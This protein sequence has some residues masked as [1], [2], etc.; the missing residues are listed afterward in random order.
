LEL[1]GKG[2]RKRV[3]FNIGRWPVPRD[4]EE[5][6]NWQ[7]PRG[8]LKCVFGIVVKL[9][10]ENIGYFLKYFFILKIYKNNIFIFNINILKKLKNT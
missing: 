1:T 6:Y 10:L 2:E 3:P 7:P 9:L 4:T 5:D 8:K